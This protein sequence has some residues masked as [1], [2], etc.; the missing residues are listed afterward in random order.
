M[1]ADQPQLALLKLQE[2]D[3]ALDRLRAERE[4]LP[5]RAVHAAAI[6]GASVA[7]DAL[8]SATAHAARLE[9]AESAAEADLAKVEGRAAS[10][11]AHARSGELTA[12]RDLERVQTEIA[13]LTTKASELEDAAIELLEAREAA[14]LGRALAVEAVATADAAVAD[15]AQHLDEAAADVTARGA[16]VFADRPGAVALVPEPLLAEYER[17]RARIAGGVAVAKLV[18]NQCQPC[19]MQRSPRDVDRFKAL[20]PDVIV[21]CEECSRILVRP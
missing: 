9:A 15:A 11:D 7:A 17:L 3:T 21:R 4:R 1:A 5:A 12:A 18:A 2:V 19:F 14:D 10:L 20:G 16:A 6:A 13:H 8:L